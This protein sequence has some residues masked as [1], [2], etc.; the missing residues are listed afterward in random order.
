LTGDDIQAFETAAGRQSREVQARRDLIREGERPRSVFLIVDG[1]ACR[2][3]TL[4][5]G[6][7]QIVAFMVPGDLCDVSSAILHQADHSVGAITRLKV[8]EIGQ[9]EFEALIAAR[10]MLGQALRWS[11]LVNSAIQRE[12]TLSL[13][14]RTAFERISHLL[15]ETYVRLEA[16]GKA[17]DNRCDFPLTQIDLADATGLTPVHVNRTLQ[18][19]RRCGLVELGNKKLYIPDMAA[20]CAAAMFNHDYLHAPVGS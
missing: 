6:R 17:R 20:L 3:K 4:P 13:G 12:W 15:C 14:Q 19:L 10:P 2:Y 7:R 5:D 16:I 1:W 18:E 11:E 8:A 9:D